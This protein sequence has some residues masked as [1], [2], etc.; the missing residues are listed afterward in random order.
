MMEECQCLIVSMIFFL[1]FFLAYIITSI[2]YNLPKSRALIVVIRPILRVLQYKV[3]L[4]S[5]SVRSAPLGLFPEIKHSVVFGRWI[6][7]P[8]QRVRSKGWAK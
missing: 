1:I 4:L 8:T 5:G 3:R 2:S 7:P 6:F